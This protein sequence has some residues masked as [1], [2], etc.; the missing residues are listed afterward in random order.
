LNYFHPANK[1]IIHYH[2]NITCVNLLDFQG[3]PDETVIYSVGELNHYVRDV[4]GRDPLLHR[5]WVKGEISNLVNHGSGHKYF[6][7]KDS[8]AQLSCVMFRNYC[9]NLAFEPESGMKVLALGDIDV[10]EVRGNYQLVVTA[11]KPD[12]I[13]DLHRAL[14]ILKKKLSAQGL[15]DAEHKKPLPRFPVCIGV[16]TSPTGAVV[17][18]IINVTRRR[19]PVNILVAPTIVQGEMAAESIV[20]S[21][22]RLNRMDVDVIILAR[23]GGSLEDLWPFNSEA[24]AQAIFN[25]HVPVVSA[26]GHET[27]FTIADLA[28]DVRA[29]TPSAAA[30]LVV[31]DRKEVKN[32]VDAVKSRLVSSIENLVEQHSNHLQH[33]DNSLDI[34]LFSRTLN[35]FMQRTDELEMRL[36]STTYRDLEKHQKLLESCVGRLNAVSPL[37]ILKRGYSIVQH[38]DKIVRTFKQVEKGDALEIR[39][40]DGKI[41]CNVNST[42]EDV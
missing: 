33:L 32:Q 19:F 5:I 15:F 27:D 24:V 28:A 2:Y 8:G 10:Y 41:Y 1:S 12:G 39:V 9:R 21:I 29:P 18:D 20:S 3:G 26:V 25:S 38:D 14:E 4:I 11:L 40:V 23:G 17:H 22:E 37:N 34:R 42:E 30:E 35:Q 6:T 31:P 7:L 13:G 16:A 36:K